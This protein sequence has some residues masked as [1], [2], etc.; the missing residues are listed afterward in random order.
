M[1]ANPNNRVPLTVSIIP[2]LKDDLRLIADAENSS[3]SRV[4]E[5]HMIEVRNA[6]PLFFTRS[7]NT[8]D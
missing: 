8:E 4:V 2:D 1:E 5:N 7:H 3:V 6:H